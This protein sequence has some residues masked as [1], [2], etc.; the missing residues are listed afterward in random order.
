MAYDGPNKEAVVGDLGALLHTGGAQVQ[1]HL[2]VGTGQRLQVE[3]AHAVEL[4]LKGQRRLQVPVDTVLLELATW[5][6]THSAHRREQSL[7]GAN[8]IISTPN[9]KAKGIFYL[10]SSSERE[11]LWKFSLQMKNITIYIS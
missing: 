6:V 8:I 9:Q 3:V 10:I 5:Q 2:V 1:V 4:Q 7:K 11:E